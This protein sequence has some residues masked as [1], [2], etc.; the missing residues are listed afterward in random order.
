MGIGGW[1]VVVGCTG[2]YLEGYLTPNILY[3]YLYPAPVPLYLLGATPRDIPETRRVNLARHRSI[4]HCPRRPRD[5][6]P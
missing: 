6:P 4:K 1:H 2:T 5:D 3:H